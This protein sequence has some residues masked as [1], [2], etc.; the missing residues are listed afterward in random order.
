[1][2]K[3]GQI[4]V[5]IILG[6]FLLFIAILFYGFFSS[7]TDRSLD[8][9][10]RMLIESSIDS[11]AANVFADDCVDEALKNGLLE[12]GKYGGYTS[13]PLFSSST[14]FEGDE[15][16]SLIIYDN[17]SYVDY[18]CTKS[19]RC[20]YPETE[21]YAFGDSK[22]DASVVRNRLK[23]YV[24]DYVK[25]CIN[26]SDVL[27]LFGEDFKVNVGEYDSNKSKIIM[28]DESVTSVVH[29]PIFIETGDEPAKGTLRFT[30][31]LDVP[32]QKILRMLNEGAL[33]KE[34]TDI[35][36][37]INSSILST[38]DLSAS[39]DN[40][41]S[42]NYTYI[43]MS[44]FKN[45][46][47]DFVF[48]FAI[49]NRPPVLNYIPYKEGKDY[50]IFMIINSSFKTPVV[51]GDPDDN[52]FSL[53]FECSDCDYIWDEN[54]ITIENISLGYHDVNF[55]ANDS[56][57]EDKMFE[58]ILVDK[59]MN[60]SFN[61][62]VD[63]KNVGYL[64]HTKNLSVNVTSPL[65]EYNFINYSY[66]LSFG[67]YIL[68]DNFLADEKRIISR[69]NTSK[70]YGLNSGETY[71]ITLH[72][73][74]IY[75]NFTRYSNK[76]IEVY[77]TPCNINDPCCK[78]DSVIDYSTWKIASEGSKCD[79]I[80][81]VSECKEIENPCKDGRYYQN[82]SV[83]VCDG[84]SSKC[85]GD[86]EWKV[87]TDGLCNSSC[88]GVDDECN[89]IEPGSYIDNENAF[90]FP[91]ELEENIAYDGSD[92]ENDYKGN[93]I[94]NFDDFYV[95]GVG[96]CDEDDICHNGT[97]GFTYDLKEKFFGFICLC[98]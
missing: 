68:R 12:M 29:F 13:P 49:E 79:S 65:S 45:V 26:F 36:Y 41:K 69:D 3:K 35:T 67:N 39:V 7:S 8:N 82:C 46:L 33:Y 87:I 81:S 55:T 78:G 70:Q 6:L 62:I 53:D 1:M 32:L 37:K 28:G 57:L 15:Y 89:G 24:G 30:G 60:T 93:L 76:T 27:G 14:E 31:N 19:V 20:T 48:R 47:D 84:L 61:F 86:S 34:T 25:N 91:C 18:P 50:D 38:Y 9:Q 83:S 64:V 16:V 94:R 17:G 40:T 11:I 75:E 71:N 23:I 4:T 21:S 88:N 56:I 42:G 95:W 5:F 22:L 73:Y 59:K 54:N 74:W 72:E 52:S 44:D 97:G 58:K 51:A 98:E 43:K 10:Q 63:G 66:N 77:V 2:N 90:C 96:N 80:E 92:L 85:K